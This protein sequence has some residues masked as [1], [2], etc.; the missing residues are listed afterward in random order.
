[1]FQSYNLMHQ[2]VLAN[3]ELALTI[4]GISGNDRRERAKA[5]L[6][7]V[8]SEISFTSA[9]TRCPADRCKE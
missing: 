3:V 8:A 5:A 1:M 6:E 4:S 7:K 2:S 9:L